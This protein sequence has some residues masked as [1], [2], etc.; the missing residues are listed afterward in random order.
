[1]HRVKKR[2]VL[3]RQPQICELNPKAVPLAQA[4]L[5]KP[6]RKLRELLKR[7]VDEI[8]PEETRDIRAN[9]RRLETILSAVNIAQNADGKSLLKHIPS[10]R[11]AACQV[12][13]HQEF[14][15]NYRKVQDIKFEIVSRGS[16]ASA[17]KL[18][19]ASRAQEAA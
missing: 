5:I 6:L 10:V 18:I 12:R 15:V 11:K 4:K 1:M 14:F 19:D 9:C 16:A 8:S 7:N 13:G 3:G 17:L 2:I